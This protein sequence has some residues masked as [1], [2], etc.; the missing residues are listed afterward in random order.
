[1]NFERYWRSDFHP[2]RLLMSLLAARAERPTSKHQILSRP[3]TNVLHVTRQVWFKW[4]HLEIAE[5][6][7]SLFEVR[8]LVQILINRPWNVCVFVPES[9]N[10]MGADNPYAPYA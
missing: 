3:Q 7:I 1:M 2:F 4:T 5:Q 10:A 9:H 8:A 6:S